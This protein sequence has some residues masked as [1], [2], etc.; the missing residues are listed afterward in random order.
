MYWLWERVPALQQVRAKGFCTAHQ[1]RSKYSTLWGYTVFEHG[2]ISLCV[3]MDIWH[4]VVG[5]FLWLVC[6]MLLCNTSLVSW[7]PTRA[8]NHLQNT[9]ISCLVSFSCQTPI[10]I[11]K[12][13][14]GV[15]LM[16]RRTLIYAAGHSNYLPMF[17]AKPISSP[18][19]FYSPR[20]K[21]I[22]YLKSLST[23]I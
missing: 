17:P 19:S 14:R 9:C 1:K 16:S 15:D 21:L 4:V 5:C 2:W 18:L 6:C 10:C 22:Y 7:L 13:L 12:R 11:Q 23:L 3:R 20:M 8:V